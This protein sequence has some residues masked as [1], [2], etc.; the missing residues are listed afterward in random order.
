VKITKLS[1]KGFRSLHDVCWEPGDLNV[2]IG[3]N[4][5]GK[6]NVLQLLE[7]LSSAA[8]GHL[9][10]DVLGLGGMEAIVWDGRSPGIQTE[11]VT[12]NDCDL[13]YTLDFMRLGQSA[14]YI[15]TNEELTRFDGVETKMILQRDPQ[16][17]KL[18]ADSQ[19]ES[20]HPIDRNHLSNDETLLSTFSSPMFAPP[21]IGEYRNSLIRWGIHQQ[22]FTT[23]PKA[24]V[25]TAAL[26]S[27][28]HS[29][30]PD[31]HNLI[32][33][34]HTLTT[35]VPA[36]KEDLDDALT[37]AF[38]DE[39]QEILFPPAADGRIQL[40]VRWKS[41]QR[42]QTTAELSDGTL[43]FLRLIAILADPN[44]PS[45]I[46]I[47]EPE[48]GLHPSMLPIVAEFALQ[49][50]LETQVVIA[51][52]SPDFLDAFTETPPTTTIVTSVEGK[53]RLVTPSDEELRRWLHDY[54]LGKM[55]RRGELE[56]LA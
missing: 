31:G 19:P 49:A 25:R 7:L 15:I 41:L 40:R 56:A 48:M 53:T 30:A 10:D 12:S 32:P 37:A 54:S 9:W 24:P 21:V 50:A 14:A 5:S 22:T 28:E 47:D 34:L 8:H 46:A 16:F 4:G 27:F 45:L 51:T 26:S 23:H 18:Y 3:P 52:H 35:T 39:Y 44:P 42:P 29:L 33:V 17:A 43:R 2:L 55:Y 11:L 13:S 36:F 1:V 38:P 20:K 6:S